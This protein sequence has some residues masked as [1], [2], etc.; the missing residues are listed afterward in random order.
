MRHFSEGWY[1]NGEQFI[2][3][4]SLRK[5]SVDCHKLWPMCLGIVGTKFVLLYDGILGGMG[6][7]VDDINYYGSVK[8]SIDTL[9]VDLTR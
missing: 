5:K 1:G 4:H 3:S 7:L 8:L 9:G 6:S 2:L